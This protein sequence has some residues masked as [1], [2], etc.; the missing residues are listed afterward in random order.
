MSSTTHLVLAAAPWLNGTVT[1]ALAGCVV[2]V[3]IVVLR[4]KKGRRDAAAGPA[5]AAGLRVEEPGGGLPSGL[6]SV[7]LLQ[8]GR[9][10]RVTAV[11]TGER[12][13]RPLVSFC[14]R[15]LSGTRHG[16]TAH[17]YL[18]VHL[19][20]AGTDPLHAVSLPAVA[21]EGILDGFGYV[22]V[23]APRVVRGNDPAAAAAWAARPALL[24]AAGDDALI[25]TGP[26]GLTLLV[27]G[28]PEDVE[29]LEAAIDRAL[30]AAG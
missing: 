19:P 9:S 28:G 27:P 30:R 5:R 16:P 12:S 2:G 4:N 10:V 17:R 6:G 7:A 21:P 8:T 11:A 13:G 26:A 25:E 23:D 18:G 3:L 15:F 29:T 22:A 14:L 20:D 1:G 24:K